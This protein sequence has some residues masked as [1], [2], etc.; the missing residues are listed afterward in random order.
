MSQ[1]SEA[2]VGHSEI[3]LQE[4]RIQWS[5]PILRRIPAKE[6]ELGVGI[7]AEGEVVGS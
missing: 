1:E 3:I 6:A 5:R 2:G 7:H 4:T